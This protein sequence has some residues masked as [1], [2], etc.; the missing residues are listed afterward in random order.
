MIVNHLNCSVINQLYSDVPRSSYYYPLFAILLIVGLTTLGAF[1]YLLFVTNEDSI[2]GMIAQR[3]HESSYLA[4][5]S[6]V[7]LSFSVS[8]TVT[9]SATVRELTCRVDVDWMIYCAIVSPIASCLILIFP[10]VVYKSSEQLKY[11]PLQTDKAFGFFERTTLRYEMKQKHLYEMGDINRYLID[12]KD[13]KSD[14]F[15]DYGVVNGVNQYRFKQIVNHGFN[16]Q[17]ETIELRL[18]APFITYDD[19]NERKFVVAQNDPDLV[20]VEESCCGAMKKIVRKEFH[21]TTLFEDN[22]GPLVGRVLY[23]TSLWVKDEK[24]SESL[25]YISVLLGVLLGFIN[26]FGYADWKIRKN[27]PIGSSKTAV[28]VLIIGVLAAV[29]LSFFLLM[30]VYQ[31]HP[32]VRT[33][34]EGLGLLLIY[35][36]ILSISF[37]AANMI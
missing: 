19:L 12:F 23:K 27:E 36:S 37:T 6:I 21:K 13:N 34:L 32:K 1:I 15:Y 3:F 7:A 17:S 5:I 29:C 11:I 25:H 9:L 31:A 8:I 33:I 18:E 30:R 26:I 22:A 24:N 14:K 10:I 4:I 20:D 28:A 35:I 2:S 16:R